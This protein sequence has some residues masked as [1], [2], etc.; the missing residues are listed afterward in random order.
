MGLGPKPTS[1]RPL[2]DWDDLDK[3]LQS[4]FQTQRKD[5]EPSATVDLSEYEMSFDD[6]KREAALQGYK[7][8]ALN[9]SYV[10]FT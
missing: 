10:K 8:E 3:F 2:K 4:V 6:V 9:G 1:Q 7:V 5:T